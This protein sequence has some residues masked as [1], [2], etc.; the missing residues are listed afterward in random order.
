VVRGTA[1]L[2]ILKI[3]DFQR[4]R[5]PRVERAEG[6]PLCC[7][8]TVA[9]A[10]TIAVTPS[11]QSERAEGFPVFAVAVAVAVPP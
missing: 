5:S 3:S 2:V 9:V 10:V 1:S 6:F 7:A 11:F 4:Q 8:V